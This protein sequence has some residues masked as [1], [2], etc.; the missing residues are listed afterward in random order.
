MLWTFLNAILISFA[1]F[2]RICTVR[3]DYLK[4]LETHKDRIKS[5]FCSRLYRDAGYI[6]FGSII[7]T[8]FTDQLKQCFFKK[9]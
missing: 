8:I 4:V 7:I 3:K 2:K 6:V 1:Y 9:V 5:V